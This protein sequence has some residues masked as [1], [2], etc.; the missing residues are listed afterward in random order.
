MN[1]GYLPIFGP[2]VVF[3]LF[4]NVF[5]TLRELLNMQRAILKTEWPD[6]DAPPPQILAAV[7]RPPRGFAKDPDRSLHVVAASIAIRSWVLLVPLIAYAVLFGAYFDFV[8]PASNGSHQWQYRTRAKQV[9]DLLV[10]TG[11]WSGFKPLAPSI[12]DN[13]RRLADDIQN[14]EKGTAKQDSSVAEDARRLRRLADSIPWIYPPFQT[15]VYMFGFV[16]RVITWTGFSSPSRW[17]TTARLG[18][19]RSSPRAAR[20]IRP[21]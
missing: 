15:W 14:P 11:G 2:F 5:V 7:A 6:G 20:R 19:R 4:C 18:C 9:A 3:G 12:Q 21:A 17:I 10:G 16:V 1:V 13:L 8:R